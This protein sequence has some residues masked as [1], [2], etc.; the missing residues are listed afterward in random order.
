LIQYIILNKY[1][2]YSRI[3]RA[4]QVIHRHRGKIN[5]QR[6]NIFCTKF[7]PKNASFE[8]SKKSDFSLIIFSLL[9]ITDLYKKKSGY[10]E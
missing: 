10:K 9:N 5:P 2:G 1:K 6:T 8:I 7:Y 4:L 3:R